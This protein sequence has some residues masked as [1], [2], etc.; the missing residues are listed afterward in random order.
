MFKMRREISRFGHITQPLSAWSCGSLWLMNFV[1]SCNH[2]PFGSQ[3]QA[4]QKANWYETR[5]LRQYLDWTSNKK[6]ILHD[7][8]L[9]SLHTK[10]IKSLH[11]FVTLSN[12]HALCY[13]W[14]WWLCKLWPILVTNITCLEHIKVVKLKNWVEMSWSRAFFHTLFSNYLSA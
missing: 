1:I 5:L 13:H 6:L 2:A 7:Y 3:Q 9:P 8:L 10:A 12:F 14:R 4:S 11:F